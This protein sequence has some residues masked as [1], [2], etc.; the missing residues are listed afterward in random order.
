VGELEIAVYVSCPPV[1][2]KSDSFAGRY[3]ALLIILAKS[4]FGENPSALQRPA[5]TTQKTR[6]PSTREARTP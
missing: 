2:K 1:Y 4:I 5:P 6:N 3:S